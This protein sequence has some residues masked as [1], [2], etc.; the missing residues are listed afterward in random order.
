MRERW[1][2]Q[3][4][5]AMA[6]LLA[7]AT[8]GCATDVDEDGDEA[9]DVASATR[10]SYDPSVYVFYG[11]GGAMFSEGVED[12]AR[13]TR[14]RVY[15]WWQRSSVEQ[16]IRAEFAAGRISKPIKIAGHSLG[17]N[18]ANTLAN[19]LVA[20]GVPV[21]YVATLD[22]T[23]PDPVDRRVKR[24]DNFMSHDFRARD[25]PGARRYARPDL[26]HIQLDNDPEVQRIVIRGIQGRP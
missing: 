20:A 26:S 11:L 15:S 22:A 24:A 3:A 17:G 18:A 21:A 7:G 19:N 9:D 14:G 12:I 6:L 1:M 5:G 10:T 4:G 8:V 2:R 25:V 13:A 16:S 23:A